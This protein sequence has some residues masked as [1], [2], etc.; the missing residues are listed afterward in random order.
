MLKNKAEAAFQL[1][2]KKSSELAVPTYI[3]E[4]IEWIRE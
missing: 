1:L 3:K 4:A 2:D